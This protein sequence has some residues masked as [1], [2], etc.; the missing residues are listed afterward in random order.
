MKDVTSAA[1][2]SLRPA[3]LWATSDLDLA[4]YLV[5]AGCPIHQIEPPAGHGPR[6]HCLA[7]FK[8][9][10]DLIERVARWNSED[11]VRGDLREYARI[12][13]SVYRWARSVNE[14]GGGR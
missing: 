11:G 14:V 12:R 4:A 2:A 7:V 1:G 8:R 5:L 9:S 13:H 6:R 10:E 3:H